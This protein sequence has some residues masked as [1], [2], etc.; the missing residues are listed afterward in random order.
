VKLDGITRTTPL[1]EDSIPGFRHVLEA[2]NLTLGGTNFIFQSW[3]DGGAQSH[4]VVIPEQGVSAEATYRTVSPGTLTIASAQFA[5]NFFKVQFTSSTGRLYRVEFASQ[6]MPSSW[7]LLADFIPGTGGLVEVPDPTANRNGQ[8]FYRVLQMQQVNLGLPNFASAAEGRAQNV[9]SLSMTLNAPGENRVLLAGVCWYG[10]DRTITS[11]TY[12]GVPC[13]ALYT[14]NWFYESGDLALY[15]LT[16]PPAGSAVLRVTFSAVA[17]E[18]S[19]AGMIV[20]NANQSISVRAVAGR[21]GASATSG[22]SVAVPSAA[23]DLVVD[24]LGYAIFTPTPGAGQ[25]E[26]LVS[27]SPNKASTRMST[28][29]STSNSTT[30]SWSTDGQSELSQ[31]GVSVPKR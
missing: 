31:I 25:T 17:P 4:E 13:V 9:S 24:V 15:Y 8:R 16:A 3:S 1:L 5:G 14:T 10:G 12:G 21:Y 19:L 7:N 20:T 11:V 26:R 6:L 2:P 22:S 23:D 30:M 27:D 18:V 28:K 29:R